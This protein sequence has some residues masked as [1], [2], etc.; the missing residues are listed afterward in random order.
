MRL[1]GVFSHHDQWKSGTSSMT[2]Y[3]LVAGSDKQK[4]PNLK[5]ETEVLILQ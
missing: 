4:K 3:I 2:I 1:T 5:C